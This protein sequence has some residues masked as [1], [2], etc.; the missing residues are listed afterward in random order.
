MKIQL[1]LTIFVA[2]YINSLCMTETPH[3]AWYAR[4]EQRDWIQ[5]KSND[6][7]TFTLDTLPFNGQ[8]SNAISLHSHAFGFRLPSH[9]NIDFRINEIK[10]ISTLKWNQLTKNTCGFVL[11]LINVSCLRYFNPRKIYDKN[12]NQTMSW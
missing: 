5:L 3:S 11:N 6:K 8:H 9:T 4:A 10:Q 1:G 7:I 2:L 12:E